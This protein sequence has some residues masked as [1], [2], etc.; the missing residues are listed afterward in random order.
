MERAMAQPLLTARGS[1]RFFPA[2]CGSKDP[3]GAVA[4]IERIER[5]DS[6]DSLDSIEGSIEALLLP[7]NGMIHA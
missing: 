5:I 6:I 7:N 3:C 4:R 2:A 1:A